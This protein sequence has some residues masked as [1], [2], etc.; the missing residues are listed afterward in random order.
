MNDALILEEMKLSLS[1][2]IR[3]KTLKTR[4]AHKNRPAANKNEAHPT[5]KMEI[6]LSVLSSPLPD[7]NLIRTESAEDGIAN[8]GEADVAPLPP[9]WGSAS[10]APSAAVRGRLAAGGADA[11]ADADD[12]EVDADA[13]KGAV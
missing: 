11:D 6:G 2:Q 3:L 9:G 8:V 1:E 5:Q 13:S 10:S 12:D 7:W 4:L